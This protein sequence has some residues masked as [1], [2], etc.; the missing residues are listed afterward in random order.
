LPSLL[1]E[2]GVEELPAS[3]CREAEAQLPELARQHLGADATQVLVG[4]RRLAL[5][6]EDLPDPATPVW[7]KGP[8]VTAPD[9][10]REGFAR[11][12]GRTPGELEERDGILGASVPGQ[13]L[14]A[15]L[16]AIVE[17][18]AFGKS[19]QWVAGG[20]RFAR[21]VRWLLAR[22]DSDAVEFEAAGLRSGEVSFG[23]RFTSG[24]G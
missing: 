6:V 16:T 1:L 20:H 12:Y 18:L 14:D 5:I 3:A 24:A 15:R 2:I 7:I 21:P 23:H 8:P 17:G 10:A 4:P 9:K 11:R 19:M 22:L 13:P